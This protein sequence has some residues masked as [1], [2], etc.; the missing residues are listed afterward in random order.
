MSEPVTI[1]IT[2]DPVNDAPTGQ[3][4]SHA[5]DEDATL[6]VTAPGV[7]A[8]AADVDDVALTAVKASDPAN[9]TVA[10]NAEGSFVYTPA[11]NFNGSDSFT[12][13]VSDGA[14]VSAPVTVSITVRSVNDL[15]TIS[16]TASTESE[17]TP[18]C[19]DDA[20]LPTGQEW[21]GQD[22]PIRWQ[23]NRPIG[24]P[25]R[26]SNLRSTNGSRSYASALSESM[27][28]ISRG[29]SRRVGIHAP[30]ERLGAHAVRMSATARA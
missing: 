30:V 29:R 10:V 9:G 19:S 4:S 7:L 1:T 24:A 18:E 11:A 8:G 26:W 2:V 6:T 25:T 15:P 23:M 28:A 14:A 12:V 17:G 27:T 16:E 21:D 5:V 20:F 22:M 13:T 3:A